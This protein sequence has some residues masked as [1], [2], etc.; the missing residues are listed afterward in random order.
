ML[1]L[2]WSDAGAE[3]LAAARAEMKY[4]DLEDLDSL[5]DEAA[6]SDGVVHLA[7]N[8]DFWQLQKICDDDRKAIEA[9]GEMLLG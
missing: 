4:G 2:T 8:H 9:I 5:R 7:F 1:G 3:A 6:K